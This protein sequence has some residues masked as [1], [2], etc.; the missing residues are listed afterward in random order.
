MVHVSEHPQELVDLYAKLADHRRQLLR[1]L[2]GMTEEQAEVHP[3]GEWS[4]KQQL[5]HLCQ[6]EEAWVDWA[7]TVL[8]NPGTQVGQTREEGQIFTRGVDT[9]DQFPLKYW[10]TRLKTARAQTLRRIAS[11]NLTPENLQRKGIHRTFGEMTVLQFL[12]ALYRHDRMHMDQIAGRPPSFI[13]G[14]RPSG[15]Q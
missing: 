9:A 13:P 3:N 7:L 1:M 11:A 6:A 8:E 12:R 4:V 15:E 10:L 2:E 5:A 14:Q